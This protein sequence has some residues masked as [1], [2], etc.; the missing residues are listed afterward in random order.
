MDLAAARCQSNQTLMGNVMGLMMQTTFSPT[1]IIIWESLLKAFQPFSRD[2]EMH[3][4]CS[5][6][7]WWPETLQRHFYFSFN[8]CA[9]LSRLIGGAES[10]DMFL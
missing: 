3:L 4:S 8:L 6:G 5:G 9:V 10:R 7:V 2:P 1:I